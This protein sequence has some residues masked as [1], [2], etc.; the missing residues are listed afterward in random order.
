MFTDGIIF[1][2]SFGMSI[3]TSQNF[4]SVTKHSKKTFATFSFSKAS[5]RPARPICMASRVCVCVQKKT[6]FVSFFSGIDL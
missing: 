5:S 6:E 3:G 1:W 2:C 4:N